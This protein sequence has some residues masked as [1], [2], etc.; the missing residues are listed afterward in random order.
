VPA[1]P[2]GAIDLIGYSNHEITTMIDALA[3]EA[4]HA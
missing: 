3:R 1:C 2:E 4:V